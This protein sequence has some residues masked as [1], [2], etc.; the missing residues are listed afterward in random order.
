LGKEFWQCFQWVVG[1]I[2]R[3]GVVRVGESAS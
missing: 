2:E 1:E 3:E